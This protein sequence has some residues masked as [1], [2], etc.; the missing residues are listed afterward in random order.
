[1]KLVKEHINFE[2]GLNPKRAMETGK[3]ILIK[4]WCIEKDIHNFIINDDFSIDVL[5]D[6]L[7]I[8][9]R[10]TS[11][12]DELIKRNKYAFN[13]Y[14][15][16]INDGRVEIHE[17]MS[18]LPDYIQ[19]NNVEGYFSVHDC[20]LTTLKGCPKEV[21][22]NFHIARNNLTNLDYCPKEVGGSFICH[23]NAEYFDKDYI[24]SKCK[25]TRSRI[26]NGKE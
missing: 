8:K 14:T 15:Q 10:P 12:K 9:P 5:N 20:G 1:M 26:Q 7:L 22:E 6:N 13:R 19:F 4:N 18:Q 24:L 21:G 25:T 16:F 23:H 11:L 3:F 2:R 17:K